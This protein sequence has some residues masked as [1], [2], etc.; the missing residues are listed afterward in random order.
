MPGILL[1]WKSL[2]SRQ[3]PIWICPKLL[4]HPHL[5]SPHSF[6]SLIYLNFITFA[7]SPPEHIFSLSPSSHFFSGWVGIFFHFRFSV[8]A[9]LKRHLSI[10]WDL[11]WQL[12]LQLTDDFLL[13]G[14]L[15]GFLWNGFRSGW[16]WKVR[17]ESVRRCL[18]SSLLILCGEKSIFP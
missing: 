6:P 2:K 9:S 13:D 17:K 8:A 5:T 15:G 16:C 12:Q 4:I 18:I 3:F 1:F 10:S 11:L 14:G 7:F